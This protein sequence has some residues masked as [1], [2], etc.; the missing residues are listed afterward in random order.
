MQQA[1]A[2][3][4]QLISEADAEHHTLTDLPKQYKNCLLILGEFFAKVNA[5]R[6]KPI[7]LTGW[8]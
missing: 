8:L 1:E 2:R 5:A 3:E 6:F 4:I 7:Q